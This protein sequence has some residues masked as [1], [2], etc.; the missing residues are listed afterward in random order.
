MRCRWV[1][2]AADGLLLGRV[3]GLFVCLFVC[4]FGGKVK[5]EWTVAWLTYKNGFARYS[6]IRN[7]KQLAIVY[8]KKG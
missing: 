1:W 2:Q 7:G 6:T 5:L 8:G 4:V 3:Q